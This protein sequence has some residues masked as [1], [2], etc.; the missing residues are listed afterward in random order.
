MPS[1]SKPGE[2]RGGR[3]KGTLNKHTKAF[4]DLLVETYQALEA[5]KGR[6][7]EEPKTGLL[8]WAKSNPTDFYRICSKL[9]PQEMTGEFNG[10]VT[11][12]VI[13]D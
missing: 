10:E 6:K 12:K 5:N 2:H 9:V 11:I 13:R 1:G 4:K 3:K 7:K 8:E